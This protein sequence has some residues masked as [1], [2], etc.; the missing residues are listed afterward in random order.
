MTDRP[1]HSSLKP[2]SLARRARQPLN[3]HSCEGPQNMT[4][5]AQGKPARRG[6]RVAT[7]QS[8]GRAQVDD[9]EKFFLASRSSI[10]R[11]LS[12]DEGTPPSV[13]HR[14]LSKTGSPRRS[15]EFPEGDASEALP[16][17]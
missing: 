5:R 14:R 11:L 1:P 9:F 12:P 8:A 4:V 13:G 17:H 3:T 16:R 6:P 7:S 2:A 15:A 10:A